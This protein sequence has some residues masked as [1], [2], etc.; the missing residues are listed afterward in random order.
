M[1]KKNYIYLFL[2]G[3]YLLFILFSLLTNYR[4]GKDIALHFITYF[5]D[6]IKIIPFAFLLIGLFEVWVKKETV[7]KHLGERS[8]AMS[9]IWAI[10]LGST[11]IGPLIVALPVASS[12]YQK[13]AGLKVVFTYVGSSAVCRI[14][15]TIFEASYMGIKFTLIRYAV[16]IPL[17]ILGSILLGNYLEKRNYKIK[18]CETAA[19]KSSSTLP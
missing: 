17:V 10:L 5:K 12:L 8:G 4:P 7:E 19:A 18:D 6:M 14:S 11:T 3:A 13:G 2:T 15:M 16:S 1:K 9:Y